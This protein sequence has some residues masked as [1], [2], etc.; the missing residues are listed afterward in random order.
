MIESTVGDAYEFVRT[1]DRKYDAVFVDVC[2]SKEDELAQPP[3]HFLS[4]DFIRSLLNVLTPTGVV[5]INTLLSNEE[6]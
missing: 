2:V 4:A 5:A 6:L 3:A 1:T